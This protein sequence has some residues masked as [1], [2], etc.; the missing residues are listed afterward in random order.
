[1]MTN[2]DRKNWKGLSDEAV[3]SKIASCKVKVSVLKNV[4]AE[5]GEDVETARHD[6]E[7]YATELIHR[8]EYQKAK[9]EES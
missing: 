2:D 5:L 9:L 1:M 7:S 6:G 8:L 3:K 4:I